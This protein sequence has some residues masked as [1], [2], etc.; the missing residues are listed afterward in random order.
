[1]YVSVITPTKNSEALISTHYR[2]VT[3]VMRRLAPAYEILYVDD[4]SRDATV[5]E[6]RRLA[7]S[8][9]RVRGLFL[10][11]SHGQQTALL[12][13]LL[14]NPS[15]VIVTIDVDLEVPAAEIEHLLDAI[16]AGA[17]YV[18]GVRRS[19]KRKGLVRWLGSHLF[20]GYLRTRTKLSIEDFGCAATAMTRALKVRALTI[21]RSYM[22]LKHLFAASA[23][24]IANVPVAERQVAGAR[25]AY[26][27]KELKRA[28]RVE[29]RK[30][31]GLD[32]PRGL[33]IEQMGAC[34]ALPLLDPFD[35]RFL[36]DPYAVYDDYRQRDPV[37]WGKPNIPGFSGTWYLTR[38]DDVIA[39]LKDRR[40]SRRCSHDDD[41]FD[42]SPASSAFTR[43][44]VVM[45]DPPEHARVRDA[46]RKT[47]F[48]RGKSANHSRLA[49]ICQHHLRRVRDAIAD[50][51]RFD[52]MTDF[53]YPYPVA[54]ISDLMG[55]PAEMNSRFVQWSGALLP[56]ID[57]KSDPLAYQRAADAAREF[58]VFLKDFL[59]YKRRSPGDDLLSALH[60]LQRDD[61]TLSTDELVANCIFLFVAGHETTVNLLGNGLAAL[62]DHPTQWDRLDRN[63]ELVPAA[64]EELLRYDCAVQATSRFATDNVVIGD[65]L[66]RRGQQVCLL[67]GA[68]NRDP[69][70]FDTPQALDV[71]R[72]SN[73]HVSFGIGDHVC[74]GSNLARME[75]GIA[76]NALLDALSGL[77]VTVAS[78]SRRPSIVFRGFRSLELSVQATV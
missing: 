17:D 23:D 8:D 39:V 45:K 46:L 64:I 24:S 41:D 68:A 55:L 52:F 2:A 7:R 1:M 54:V 11:L 59:D 28:I 19:T 42:R 20:H 71:G 5:S 56:A 6:I 33:V 9:D 47:F 30:K 10:D 26:G 40:F 31:N 58:E 49:E 78:S 57:F 35:A 77:R 51:G 14:D 29:H 13:G 12:V 22:G 21:P 37:H 76:I 67:L 66:I 27:F 25:S 73:R 38:Y 36:S 50:I 60:E 74:L 32:L 3:A 75:A 34:A 15:D 61:R 62:L 43:H 53:A 16:G 72:K 4:G 48:R 65:K 44:W 63:R 69:G 18:S 70:Q